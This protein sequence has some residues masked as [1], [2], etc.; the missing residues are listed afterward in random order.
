MKPNYNMI[1][2]SGF[3]TFLA[4]VLLT[5]IVNG[6]YAGN[7][8]TRVPPIVSA[9]WL[10]ENRT[11][12]DIVILHVAPVKRDYETGHIPGA[13]FLWPGYIIIST[14]TE[15]TLSAPVENITKVLRTLG[16]NNNSHVVLCGIYGNIIPVCRV[17][18]NLE[19]VGLKGR[20]SVLDGGFDAWKAAGYEV[21]AVT[22]VVKK[23]KFTA[24]VNNNLADGNWMIKNLTNKSYSIIDAR[25]KPLYDGTTGLP[26][27]GHIPGAKSLPQTVLYDSKTF[28]FIDAEKLSEA[29]RN[30]EIPSGGKPVLY[31]HTGN[32]ASV[33]YV[34]ALA[35]GYDPVLYE[36]SMEEW[37]SRFDLPVEK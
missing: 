33:A 26:R 2:R 19:H 3:R 20:V 22:P 1:S 13:E 24:T 35:A 28:Q 36:G 8:G 5:G 21:S 32:Q 37:A 15:T 34:A 11:N 27:A 9:K 29:F 23:G 18:V 31:C 12:P 14:E 16:V 6:S 30:L 7:E 25:A 17:F 10:A 4:A